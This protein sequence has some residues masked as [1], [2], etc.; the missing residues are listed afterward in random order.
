MTV[1]L[2]R[3]RDSV[4]DVLGDRK[5]D[6][7]ETWLR[8][9]PAS[10]LSSIETVTMEM[11]E[12]FMRATMSRV[13]VAD[14]KICFDEF[15]VSRHFGMALGRVRAQEHRQF[16]RAEGTS[17]LTGTKDDW[18]RNSGLI[19]NRS[20]RDSRA[21]SRLNLRTA[22][23]WRIKETAAE[24]WNYRYR[25]VAENAWE[26]PLGW[27]ARCRLAPVKKCGTL[28]RRTLRGIINAMAEAKNARVQ[29]IKNIACGFRNRSRFRMAIL[30]HLGGLNLMPRRVAGF[31]L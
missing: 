15:H 25:A 3:D 28:I 29:R 20:R 4:V 22:R 8:G 2:D 5:A 7:L 26:C 24:P 1:I 23:G 17:P 13:P 10:H 19:D 30:V 27:I 31:P 12:P 16:L 9:R 6:T 14:Q 21:L 11:W 18:Q